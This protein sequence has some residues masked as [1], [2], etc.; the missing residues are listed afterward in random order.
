MV[1]AISQ[2]EKSKILWEPGINK[3]DALMKKGKVHD[4]LLRGITL[5]LAKVKPPK[6]NFIVL[7][8][9]QLKLQR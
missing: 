8:E 2:K 4:F 7:E 9:S 6:E 1:L 3:I 5:N